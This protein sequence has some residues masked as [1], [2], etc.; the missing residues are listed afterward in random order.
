ELQDEISGVVSH[1]VVDG[2][3]L[4]DIDHYQRDALLSTLSCLYGGAEALQVQ[5]ALSETGQWVEV[6]EI[7][8][9][10]LVVQ[11]LQRERDAGPDLLEQREL[12]VAEHTGLA[13][14]QLDDADRRPFDGER[15]GYAGS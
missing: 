14:M 7:F 8:G 12:G 4:A 3:E 13:G 2:S 11:V 5:P 15:H 6:L 9:A 1:A 10:L